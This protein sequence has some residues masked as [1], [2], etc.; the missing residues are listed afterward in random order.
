[1]RRRFIASASLF[2]IGLIAGSIGPE[3]ARV[4]PQTS[5]DGYQIL[6]GDFHVHAFPGDGALAPWD[7]AHEARRNGLDVIAITNHNQ[8]IAAHL[9][10]SIPGVMVLPGQEI[11]MPAF[12]M[13]AINLR[14][15]VDWRGTIPDV[16]RAV[17]A[18][19]GVAIGAHP[20]RIF[21][22][23]ITEASIVALDGLERAHPMMEFRDIDR[24]KLADSFDRALHT[25]PSIAPIGSSDFHFMAAI[26]LCRTYLFVRD[27]TP[28]G[29]LDAI[30]SGRTVACDQRGNVYG[31]PSLTQDVEG[32]C[33]ATAAARLSK[34]PIEWLSLFCTW[35]G[36]AGLV[37]MGFR[38]NG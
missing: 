23:S 29:V 34:P 7:L 11:T 12:H 16:A 25:K 27:A 26:G 6:A 30:R 18:Q 37:W 4:P 38:P 10:A 32:L 15:T 24:Q 33:R 21:A 9:A 36:L 8:M 22:S 19:G 1:M 31:D 20:A 28:A 13:T 35:L 3:D 17:H 5:H 14:D 2:V